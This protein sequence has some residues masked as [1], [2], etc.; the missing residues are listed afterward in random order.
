MTR[1]AFDARSDSA[2]DPVAPRADSKPTSRPVV[3]LRLP[4]WRGTVGERDEILTQGSES[5][6]RLLERDGWDPDAVPLFC[7]LG[8]ASAAHQR[9]DFDEMLARLEAGKFDL[10]YAESTSQ[11]T[12][13]VADG[14]RL[15]RLLRSGALQAIV[16]TERTFLAQSREQRTSYHYPNFL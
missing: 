8:G 4:R 5:L 2:P 14:G 15:M 16:T 11:L 10:L 7:D 13:N 1:M 9:P 3:Y 6:R 12:R